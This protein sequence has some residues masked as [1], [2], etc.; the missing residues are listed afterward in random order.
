MVKNLPANAGDMCLIP[1]S[2]RSAGEGNGDCSNFLAWEIPW[3]ATV[4]GVT[5]ESDTTEQ[6]S[7]HTRVRKT[8]T[9]YKKMLF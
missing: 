9:F 3:M 6:L 7:T 8:I 4:H 1:R 2:G 5:K